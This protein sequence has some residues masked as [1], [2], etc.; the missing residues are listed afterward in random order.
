M[1]GE[2]VSWHSGLM[3]ESWAE[4]PSEAS[5]LPF[6]QQEIARHGQ[7]VLD[8][9][10]GIG[11]LLIPLL[12][13]GIEVDGCDISEDM[14]H[15]C[16]RNAK[17]QGFTPN[18]YQQ[19]MHA[20]EI[21]RKYKTIFICN[22]FD[23]AGSRHNDLET[24]Q[25]C[26]AHLEE[27]GALIFNIQAEYTLRETW[28]SWLSDRRKGLP[29]PWPEEGSR[30]IAPDG[31]EYVTRTRTL[32]VNPL[33]QHLTRQVRVEKWQNGKL[34]AAEE[35]TMHANMYLKSELLLMLKVTGFGQVS[36]R[37]DYSDAPATPESKQ[38]VFLAIK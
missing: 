9:A 22:A 30:R 37:G 19:P 35:Y 28:D 3:A 5:E 12:R 33:E 18:L 23:L 14:L 7:P 10:C 26:H 29:Y 2:P 31:S 20:F 34:I 25:C 8:L 38:L 4:C 11:R 36:L 32:D 16:Q 13:L 21:P 17:R 24:L 15:Y 27:G 6:F 1:I